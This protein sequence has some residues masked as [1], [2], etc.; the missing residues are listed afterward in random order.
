MIMPIES[1]GSYQF[2]EIEP[3]DHDVIKALHEECFPVRYSDRFYRDACMGLGFR[4][5]PLYTCLCVERSSQQVIGFIFAQIQPESEIQD[6]GLLGSQLPSTSTSTS[7]STSSDKHEEEQ[8]NHKA[9]KGSS[10]V[11][12]KGNSR[13]LCYILTLGLTAAYRRSGL[14]SLLLERCVSYAQSYK[15][16]GAVYLH[17][18]HNNP[19]AIAFYKR[20]SFIHLRTLGDFYVVNGESHTAFLL[21]LYINNFQSPVWH[22]L[23]LNVR[24]AVGGVWCWIADF[25]SLTSSS[26]TDNSPPSTRLENQNP[27]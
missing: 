8:K 7:T 12:G 23:L 24:S 13:S 25:F 2:R 1:E 9:N 3:T 11:P 15:S 22:R 16:C 10:L 5:G 20:N 27:V 26:S 4:G 17:V 19:S 14:G 6:K 18:I 21:I